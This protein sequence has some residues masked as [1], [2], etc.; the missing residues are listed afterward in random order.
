MQQNG[1]QLPVD[2]CSMDILF[3]GK[4]HMMTPMDLLEW[5]TVTVNPMSDGQTIMILNDRQTI[6]Y[7]RTVNH[8]VQY[9]SELYYYCTVVGTKIN[10][11]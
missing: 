4:F 6:S 2:V 1:P 5:I 7:Y 9:S 3:D 11:I 10:Q 8:A